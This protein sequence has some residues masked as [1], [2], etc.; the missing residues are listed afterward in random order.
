MGDNRIK[1]KTGNYRHIIIV[2]AHHN[3][4]SSRHAVTSKWISAHTE[5]SER[6]LPHYYQTGLAF[7]D[8]GKGEDENGN[9]LGDASP[10]HT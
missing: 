8:E 5:P 3:H 7:E 6:R 9:M 4:I 1:K 2:Y 10:L